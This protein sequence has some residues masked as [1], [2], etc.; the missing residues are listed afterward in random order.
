[1][2]PPIVVSIEV[3]CEKATAFTIFSEQMATWWPLSKRAMSL[4][5]GGKAKT[6]DVEARV[7]GTIVEVGEDGTRHL[8][9][10]FQRFEP[11]DILAI[12]FHMGLP[13]EQAGNVEVSFTDLGNGRT[14]VRLE[15]SNWEGYGEMAAMMRKGYAGSWGLIL[16]DSFG[17]ACEA[18]T[19]A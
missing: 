15:H 5:S 7:G 17:V 18:A 9:G 4:Y 11:H 19:L 13:P 12:A 2:L 6:L 10:T 16:A 14:A 8:W 1:M 3:A